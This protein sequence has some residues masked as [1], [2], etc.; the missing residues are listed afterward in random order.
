MWKQFL[1]LSGAAG[2]IAGPC[3][4][5]QAAAHAP[6]GLLGTWILESQQSQPNAD[7]MEF[8]SDRT[9]ALNNHG[10]AFP[11][12]WKPVEANRIQLTLPDDRNRAWLLEWKLLDDGVLRLWGLN[13]GRDV[14]TFWVR[15][16]SASRRTVRKAV[17][18]RPLWDL[19][20]DREGHPICVR[21]EQS[22]FGRPKSWAKQSKDGRTIAC[23]LCRTSYL[24]VQPDGMPYQ[25]TKMASATKKRKY[26]AFRKLV[27]REGTW[28]LQSTG[29]S[30]PISFNASRGTAF[31]AGRKWLWEE[32]GEDH[33]RV[34]YEGERQARDWKWELSD[35][36][37]VLLV[38][39]SILG[40]NPGKRRTF[41]LIRGLR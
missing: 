16:P 6:K 8:R 10:K 19:P 12:T 24:F 30:T 39:E 40:S 35:D 4:V 20:Q 29:G 18:P 32:I 33:L 31:T 34:V 11:G 1:I 7:R 27:S 37:Q 36:R 41:S 2:L 23:G 15:Q 13:R 9:L 5:A 25:P 28:Q 38:T 22:K 21:C 3:H 17:A 14:P 26:S